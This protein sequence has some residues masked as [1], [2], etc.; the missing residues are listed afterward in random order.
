VLIADQ[1]NFSGTTMHT[2]EGFAVQVEAS[3]SIFGSFQV[4]ANGA[5]ELD[6]PESGAHPTAGF[7]VP[8]DV[9]PDGF[10]TDGQQVGGGRWLFHTG[11]NGG[12]SGG[13]NRGS[14]EA[15]E[16]R[17]TRNGG[18]DG[19]IGNC[20]YEMRFTGDNSN[21]GVGG[22]YAVEAFEDDNVFWVPFELWNTGVGTPDDP[23]DDIRLIPLI[24][25]WNENNIYNLE[26]WGSGPGGTC[27]GA[28]EHSVSDGDD[29]PFTDWVYWYTSTDMSPGEAGYL[30]AEADML[31][32]NG[33]SFANLAD[34][35]F[36]R[37]VLVSWNGGET[38]PFDQECPE[39]GTVFRILTPD[40]E[41]DA[42]LFTFIPSSAIS[43]VAVSPDR[44]IYTKY[45]LFNKGGNV[46]EDAYISLWADP[47]L[48][49]YTDDLVGCDTMLDL[50]YCYNSDNHDA[51]HYEDT[52]PAVGFR[53]MSGP[54]VPG[55]PDDT[56]DF[57]GV[58]MP[59]Y[60]NLPMTAFSKYINGTDPNN[61]VETYNYMR[62]L[63]ANGTP[64]MYNGNVLSFMH[65]GDPVTN[66]GDLDFDPYDRRMMGSC[67][68]FTMMPGD[69]QYIFIKMAVGQGPDRLSSI[70]A[71]IWELVKP[72]P[73]PVVFKTEIDPDPVSMMMLNALEPVEAV[74][75]FGFDADAETYN[76][77]DFASLALNGLPPVDS[78]VVLPGW[79]GFQGAVARLYF[80]LADLLTPYQPLFDFVQHGYTVSGQYVGVELFSFETELTIYGHRS[81]DLN[82]DGKI[83]ISDLVFMV[84]Y[85]FTGGQAPELLETADLDQNGNS[86]IT[87]LLLMIE[88]MFGQ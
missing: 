66:Y 37:T 62:G 64:Y 12:T 86:D 59:G 52:P 88:L 22:S 29:D 26:N 4:V 16:V 34:E 2:D 33:Y 1:A 60:K 31:D 78:M 35:V 39:Q 72:P 8:T 65:S 79:P 77:I 36:A 43:T 55:N 51:G 40:L 83:D 18:N 54:I 19:V 81:G 45:K 57:D 15:F 47:D 48:G 23:S 50:F 84:E 82:L 17:V 46:I 27:S 53:I 13:G 61:F 28:C 74:I 56:A 58:L 3:T 42:D 75:T 68:P 9:D 6:P 30:E 21:P 80:P 14:F 11:D 49:E 10:P 44:T 87:D 76:E 24:I 71:L 67:G 5:G 25:D 70:T 20:D 85:F 32:G 38:P 69:S 41:L 7:P 73:L 63:Y